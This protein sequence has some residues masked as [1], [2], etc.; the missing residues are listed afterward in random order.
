M[1][2]KIKEGLHKTLKSGKLLCMYKH[3]YG[4]F[5]QK[6]KLKKTNEI[7]IGS[8]KTEKA[9]KFYLDFT[10]DY[11]NMFDNIEKEQ[12][13]PLPSSECKSLINDLRDKNK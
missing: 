1:A 10:K 4:D 3:Y 6:A 5:I 12:T 2:E 8:A 13:V 7:V 11:K 9:P